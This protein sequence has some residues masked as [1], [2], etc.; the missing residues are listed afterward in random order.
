[1]TSFYYLAWKHSHSVPACYWLPE[2]FQ[3]LSLCSVAEQTVTPFNGS[4]VVPT[5]ASSLLHIVPDM[6]T[7]WRDHLLVCGLRWWIK[8]ALPYSTV[9]NPPTPLPH[10]KPDPTI[11]HLHKAAIWSETYVC[12]HLESWVW[13]LL[14]AWMLFS[15][16]LRRWQP[17][18]RADHSFRGVQVTVFA[19]VW[20]R[21]L[22]CQVA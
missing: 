12:S 14:C 1:M 13:I 7:S 16:L 21:H 6:P 8:K 17:L 11:I 2:M 22:D 18:Q 3:V 20:S 10:S 19:C 9:P 15:C 5:T 4:P